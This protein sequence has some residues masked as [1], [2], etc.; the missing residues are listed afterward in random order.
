M[1]DGPLGVHFWGIRGSVPVCGPEYQRFGGNTACIELTCGEERLILDGGSGLRAAGEAMRAGRPAAVDI[2]LTHSHYDH[3]IGLPFFAPLYDP[4]TQVTL[5][6]GHLAGKMT[7]RQLLAKI[8]E[9]PL[10]PVR[11]DSC[12]ANLHY[13]DFQPGDVLCPREGVVL[14]TASLNHPGGCVGYRVEW[15]G[16]SVALVSDT[17]HEP[18]RLDAAVLGLIRDA[19]LV[20]YDATYT[21][22][23]MQRYRGF[24]H[25]TWQQ[26]IRLCKAAG[27][28]RLALFHHDP[29]RSDD[30]M[31]AI[32][33]AAKGEF[34]GAFAARDG[35]ALAL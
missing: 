16:R 27:A 22:E 2:F 21:D 14:R 13:R 23:E 3:V 24:G 9:P 10:F 8:M 7:T 32:E 26:G 12:A 5:W 29:A 4:A 33:K 18:G 1:A 28:R 6:S 31:D 11:V 20:V 25:S 35:L 15:R 34:A 17:E 30:Q 19:D